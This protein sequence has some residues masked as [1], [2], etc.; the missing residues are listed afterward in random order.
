M[1]AASVAAFHAAGDHHVTWVCIKLRS[2][3]E[4]DPLFALVALVLRF[5]PLEANVSLASD[6]IA[7]LSLF[8]L[9]SGRRRR[10]CAI[11]RRFS[12]RGGHANRPG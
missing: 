8:N 5:V 12:G 1:L 9:G 4:G 11:S 7:I 6:L 2:F 3:P 10:L